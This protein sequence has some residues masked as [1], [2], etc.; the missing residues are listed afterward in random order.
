MPKKA[1]D[2]GGYGR[3]KALLLPPALEPGKELIRR[4][5]L[6]TRVFSAAILALTAF[7]DKVKLEFLAAADGRTA[8]NWNPWGTRTSISVEQELM[9]LRQ[10]LEELGRRF[11]S[12]TETKSQG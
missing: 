6:Q 2:P 7:D 8:V 12:S 11:E 1:N 5:G 3:L 9:E 4:Y 10:G